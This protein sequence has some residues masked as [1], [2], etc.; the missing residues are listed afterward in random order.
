VPIAGR[1]LPS[2]DSKYVIFSD[3]IPFLVVFLPWKTGSASSL[4][5]KHCCPVLDI[6]SEDQEP[7][8]EMNMSAPMKS[9]I[10]S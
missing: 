7:R 3:F 9:M 8:S 10:F 5:A 2:L 6:W 4:D 1:N